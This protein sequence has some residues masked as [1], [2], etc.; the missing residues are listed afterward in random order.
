MILYKNIKLK[1]KLE[2]IECKPIF[3]ADLPSRFS[4]TPS[5]TM[6]FIIVFWKAFKKFGILIN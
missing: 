1:K 4:T 6:F 3:Q 5:K 2:D